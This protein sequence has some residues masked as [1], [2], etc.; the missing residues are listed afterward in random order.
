MD[1]TCDN[2]KSKFRIQDEKIPAGIE[3]IP[4][5]KCKN[6]IVL[7]ASQ[8]TGELNLKEEPAGHSD[9]EEFSFDEAQISDS[10]DASDKPFDFVE[11]EGK[12]ALV[13]ES[14]PERKKQ[15]IEALHIMEFNT[16]EADNSR[17]VLKRMRYHVYDL[18]VLN[19]KFDTPN[20][21]LNPIMMAI[22]RLPIS[23]RRNIFVALISD[24]FRTMD[25]MT[26]F[27]KSV[28]IIINIKNMEDFGK[29][30]NRG[31]NDNEYF[32]RIFKET[33]KKLGRT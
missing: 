15:I 33:L 5:P 1:I 23:T 20:N 4:C 17:D 2:C 29:I 31:I 10:Y 21:E 30:L 22:D 6:R 25:S 27:Q 13:C 28:N 7:S 12:T 11:E 3:S 16:N 26:A 32:Y 8:K 24:R 18:I 19:E 9:S 14:D